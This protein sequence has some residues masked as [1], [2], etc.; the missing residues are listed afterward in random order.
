[1][2]VPVNQVTPAGLGDSR[3]ESPKRSPTACP[4]SSGLAFPDLDEIK[5]SG[6]W[7]GIFFLNE[8]KKKTFFLLGQEVSWHNL[9]GGGGQ[10]VQRSCV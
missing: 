7:K 6:N 4:P 1:M 5:E 9:E 3:R 2:G 10:L 8:E